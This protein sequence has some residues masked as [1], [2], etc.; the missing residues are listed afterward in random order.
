MV[1]SFHYGSSQLLM[2]MLITALGS[3]V[4]KP[5]EVVD[6]SALQAV[7]ISLDNPSETWDIGTV[8]TFVLGCEPSDAEVSGY[9]LI[10]RENGI[11]EI[12]RVEGT[13]N[14]FEVQAIGEGN[15]T[16][17]ACADD[18][19]DS[20]TFSVVDNRPAPVAPDIA[21]YVKRLD[22][23]SE[24]V[25][26]DEVYIAEDNGEY[27]INVSTDA[28]NVQFDLTTSDE[29]I[30]GIRWGEDGDWVISAEKPGKAVIG[31]TVTDA[32]GN[33]FDYQYVFAVYGH[34][35]FNAEYDMLL[36]EGGLSLS[37]NRYPEL[38]AEVYISAQ[39]Y[40][41]PWNKTDEIVTLDAIPY[42]GTIALDDMT[43]NRYLLNAKEAQEEIQSMKYWNG[44]E[45]SN[46]N[47]H[48]VRLT[49]VISLSDPFVIIDDIKDDHDR[50]EPLYYDFMIEASLS[51][52][53]LESFEEDGGIL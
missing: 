16:L 23:Q 47:I 40:G 51:Q 53:G 15:A 8:R 27:V 36:G 4:R 19:Q 3:C 43:D 14:M 25:E 29:R 24:M 42:T 21:V 49:F 48:G 46:Y 34:I 20:L 7:T 50:S 31:L 26:L 52:E 6:T 10:S 12:A 37:V 33:S 28:E 39:I 18:K 41:W 1:K 30:A 11:F 32:D 35:E 38:C 22:V 5:L 9:N 17:V 2:L 45:W 44:S 13:D